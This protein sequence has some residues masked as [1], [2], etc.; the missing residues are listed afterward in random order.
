MAVNPAQI[1]DCAVLMKNADP[2]LYE[3]FLRLLDAYVT[4]LTVAVTEAPP[5][6]ILN[7]QGRAQQGRKFLQLFT[8]LREINRPSP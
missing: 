8:E 7:A 6:N 2:R 4:E 5:D 1:S 3:R